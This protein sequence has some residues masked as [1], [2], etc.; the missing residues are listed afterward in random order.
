MSLLVIVIIYCIGRT[1]Q[2]LTKKVLQTER[3][4]QKEVYQEQVPSRCFISL[5]KLYNSRCPKD[6]LPNAFYLTLLPN[7]KGIVGTL[8]VLWGINTLGKIVSEMMKQAGFEGHNTNH[9]CYSLVRC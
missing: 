1:F 6:H 2:R 4:K 3:K 5:Y 8:K 7:K 9:F